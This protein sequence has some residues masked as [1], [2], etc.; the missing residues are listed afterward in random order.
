[1]KK[2]LLCLLAAVMAMSFFACGASSE[3]SGNKAQKPQTST[4]KVPE[5]EHSYSSYWTADETGHWHESNCEHV[6]LRTETE[7]HVF[8]EGV[9]KAPD[10]YGGGY[11]TYTC[12]VCNYSEQRDFVPQLVHYKG[13]SFTD[14]IVMTK[15]DDGFQ[16]ATINVGF[17]ESYY[18]KFTMNQYYRYFYAYFR[19]PNGDYYG[20]ED[21]EVKLYQ[22][23]YDPIDLIADTDE[24]VP[25]WKIADRSEINRSGDS[26]FYL[27]VFPKNFV[28]WTTIAVYTDKRYTE[29]TD[30]RVDIGELEENETYHFSRTLTIPAQKRIVLDLSVHSFVWNEES[31]SGEEIILRPDGYPAGDYTVDAKFSGN[32]PSKRKIENGFR[33]SADNVREEEMKITVTIALRSK[34]ACEVLVADGVRYVPYFEMSVDYTDYD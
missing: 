8:D 31:G 13:E 12:T 17:G 7:P 20:A 9:V 32:A 15:G 1:M 29:M 16:T 11:T 21:C 5:H 19:S 14:P 2:F 26:T 27:R 4:E 6:G 33:L 22:G 28:D 18:F 30:D 23:K 34:V 25:V 3:G 10:Y 24:G